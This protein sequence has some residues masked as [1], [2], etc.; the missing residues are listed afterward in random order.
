MNRFVDPDELLEK[1]RLA[2][3]K[4]DSDRRHFLKSGL[5][6]TA[7]LGFW[8]PSLAKAAAPANARL[9]GRELRL[10]NVHTGEKFRGEYWENGRYLPD[11]FG[12]IKSVMRDHRTGDIFPIDPRLMDILYV[13]QHRL[14]NYNTF[15]VFS[16]YRSEKTNAKLRKI[17]HGVARRSLH[18]TGQAA[19]IKLPGS[20]LY[21]VRQAAVRLKSGGVGY[22]PSSGFVHVDTGRVRTW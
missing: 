22:Y 15:D 4:F 14:E 11:A 7:A 13:L 18:M 2:A 10:T 17:S 19:D 12:N 6:M 3:E 16:G 9:G 20:K 5:F 1:N 8:T 21:N